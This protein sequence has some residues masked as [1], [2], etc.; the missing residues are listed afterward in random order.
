MRLAKIFLFAVACALV[1][2][3]TAVVSCGIRTKYYALPTMRAGSAAFYADLLGEYSFLQ[4]NQ[5]RDR[6]GKAALLEYLAFLGKTQTQ[7]TNYPTK[8]LHFNS[9]LT[10][11]RLYRLETA[12]NHSAK[13]NEY[14]QAAQGELRILGQT[15][16][17]AEHLIKT[18]ETREG[19]EAKL[20]NNENE[21]TSRF[22]I[23]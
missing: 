4:Y 15:D 9:A 12:A 16:I 19:N 5:A 13:A 22:G 8:S 21:M 11:L 14:L 23:Q 17:S 2:F 20:Y 1:F 18:I 3:A 10:Y 6:Q 7:K